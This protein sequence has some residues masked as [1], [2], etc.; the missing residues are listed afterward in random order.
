MNVHD[1]NGPQEAF[2]SGLEG[3]LGGKICG[4]DYLHFLIHRGSRNR[5]LAVIK[6]GL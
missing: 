2:Q 3:G 4:V 6:D 5:T 1:L